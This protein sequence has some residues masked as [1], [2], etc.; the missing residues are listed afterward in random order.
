V[1]ASPAMTRRFVVMR[2]VAHPAHD[3]SART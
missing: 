2:R 3:D 1:T